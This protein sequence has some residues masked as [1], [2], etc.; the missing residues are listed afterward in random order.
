[1]T[2]VRLLFLFH[3]LLEQLF[4]QIFCL[5]YFLRKFVDFALLL[6]VQVVE[7]LEWNRDA[8]VWIVEIIDNIL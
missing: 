3:R 4:R 7:E 5:F 1:M 2:L 8:L 6:S